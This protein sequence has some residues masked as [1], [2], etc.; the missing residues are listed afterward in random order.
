Y[1]RANAYPVELDLEECSRL[2]PHVVQ[3]PLLAHGTP[4]RHDSDTL[5]QVLMEVASEAPALLEG[6]LQPAW[7]WERDGAPRH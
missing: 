7:A 3:R 5:A 1:K 4:L 6:S 2:V